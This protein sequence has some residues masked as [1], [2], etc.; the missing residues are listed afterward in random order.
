MREKL[1]IL[2]KSKNF[3]ATKTTLF[4]PLQRLQGKRS[5]DA[6]YPRRCAGAGCTCSSMRLMIAVCLPHEERFRKAM[7]AKE[8]ENRSEKEL[9]AKRQAH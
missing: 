3:E 6:F 4:A 7:E 5:A 2:H 9:A 1:A 8:A